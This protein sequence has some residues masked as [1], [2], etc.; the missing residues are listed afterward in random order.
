MHGAQ[1]PR[2]PKTTW[3]A[4]YTCSYSASQFPSIPLL[5]CE[6]DLVIPDVEPET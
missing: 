1:L 2:V 5:E 6:L 3:G 4:H